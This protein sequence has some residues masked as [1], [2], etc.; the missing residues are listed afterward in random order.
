[1]ARVIVTGQSI[2]QICCGTVFLSGS[3]FYP[4]SSVKFHHDVSKVNPLSAANKP[5]DLWMVVCP[6]VVTHKVPVDAVSAALLLV[7]QDVRS[8]KQKIT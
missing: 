3:S 7:Q 8:W 6:D 5:S 1:M 2:N 4:E